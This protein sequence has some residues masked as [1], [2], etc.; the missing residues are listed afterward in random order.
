MTSTA[1]NPWPETNSGHFVFIADC[2]SQQEATLLREYIENNPPGDSS[3]DVVFRCFRKNKKRRLYKGDLKP[4]VEKNPDSFFIPLRLNWIPKAKEKGSDITLLDMLSGNTTH[5][6]SFHQMVSGVLGKLENRVVQG[7]G[8]TLGQL[9]ADYDKYRQRGYEYKNLESFIER[10]ALLALEKAERDISGARYRIPR[11]LDREV[12]N[13]PAM[14]DALRDISDKTGRSVDRLSRYAKACLKEM[15]A[16]PTPVGNDMA[17]ALGRFMYTRGFDADIDFA[18]GDIERIQQLLKEKPVAFLFTHKSHIDGFLLI[19]LFHQYNL[20]PAHVFGGINMSLPGLGTLLRNSGAIF[21]RRSFG[22][23]DVYKAV[24]KNYIDYLGEKRFP[25]MWAL[26][27]T[28]SRTG[29][30]MPPRYGLIN[31]VASAY[32]RDDAQDLVMMPISICYDQVPE[33]ADYDALQAGG[34]KRPESASWFMEYLSGLKHPHGKIHVRF[35]EGV[36]LSRHIDKTNP[37]VDSRAI[38]KMA[39]DLAVDVNRATPIT[40]NGLICYVMLENGHR[41]I[42]YKELSEGICSLWQL[43]K[44]LNFV[45]STEAQNIDEASVRRN[46]TQLGDTGVIKIFNDGIESVYMIPHGS[47]R[48]A[49]YYRNGI[50]HFLTTSAIAELALM[51]VGSEG[52]AALE[53][54]RN[55][56]LRIRDILKYEFFFEGSEEFLKSLENEMEQ[57]FPSWQDKV[58]K[59]QASARSILTKIRP[60]IG[61]GTLRPFIEAYLLLARALRMENTLAIADKRALIDRALTLGKQRVLQQRIHCEESVSAN[62]FENAIK[63]AENNNLLEVSEDILIRRQQWLDELRQITANIRYLA[64][65]SEA[66]RISE[67]NKLESVMAYT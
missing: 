11:M 31:Y 15:A 17:A 42:N 59:G 51:A 13:R 19:W 14:Q 8:A 52:D 38:Q 61:H 43:A 55:E 40:L 50:L 3:Y 27:G 34:T 65:L 6:N 35:G 56:A 46:L 18:E 32:A 16:T 49:A 12:L 39:F 21:I 29:K 45:L 24:F 26:E 62:Y 23:D 54:F 58:R 67:R 2:T 53:E 36:P 20:P 25:V 63:I 9:N 30:L 57:R 41:A 64:S 28:R 33:I 44:D 4:I 47:G 37:V 48:M 22:N 10:S 66:K 7:R 60:V 5:P 1:G